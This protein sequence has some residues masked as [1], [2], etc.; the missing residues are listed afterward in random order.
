MSRKLEE[1]F[2][3]ASTHSEVCSV[4]AR[5]S[6]DVIPSRKHAY[7]MLTFYTPLLYSK[8]GVSR[9]IHYFFLSFVQNID[10]GYS[11]EP[12][13]GGG[14]NEY[15]QSMFLSR[16]R[17]NIRIFYPT[18]FIFFVVKFSVYLNRYVFV[19]LCHSSC[20]KTKL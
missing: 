12:P 14:Y 1:L 15:Q 13:R 18:I 17:K 19:M 4:Y 11:L 9:G 5:H 10:C 20:Y 8:T 16:N 2:L 7:I 3:M 6:L